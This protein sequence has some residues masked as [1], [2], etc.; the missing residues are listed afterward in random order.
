MVTG[1][2]SVWCGYSD[3]YGAGIV[4]GIVKVWCGYGYAYSEGM[5]RV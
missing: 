4:T 5:V 2:V 3:G 1:I